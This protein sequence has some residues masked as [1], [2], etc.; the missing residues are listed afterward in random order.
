MKEDSDPCTG[1]VPLIIVEGFLSTSGS[2]AWSPLRNYV[3]GYENM[4]GDRKVMIASVGPV[5][6][7][8]DRACELYYT[9]KGG[10]VDYGAEHARQSGHKRYGRHHPTGLYPI[11]SPSNPLHF[12][13]HSIGGATIM[14]LQHLLS[15]GFFGQDT[16]PDM[17]LSVTT[18]SCPF[19]GTQIVYALGER[20]DSAPAVRS[21]SVG[22]VLA[23]AVHVLSYISPLLPKALDL[24]ADSRALSYQEC[25]F[26]SFLRHL[27][28]SD[29]AEGRD[30]TPFDVT[31][32]AADERDA[33]GEGHCNPNTYYTS[34]TAFFTN[35]VS[36]ENGKHSP[37]LTNIRIPPLYFS[38]RS[39]GSFDFESLV[40]QPSFVP[41]R[42]TPLDDFALVKP[43]V[44]RRASQVEDLSEHYWAN[45]GV[46]PVFSQ[47]HP[48]ECAETRCIHHESSP[49]S[50]P[51]PS[52]RLRRH[53]EKRLLE[54]GVWNVYTLEDTHH[55][56]ILP[57][58][59][60]SSYQQN[61]WSD[62]GDFLNNIDSQQLDV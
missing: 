62:L 5:S 4:L 60:G 10:T 43:G 13:G 52:P 11:W 16:H 54:P 9:I 26:I 6:S 7:L 45:D 40:P 58:W 42:R 14:K 31:F 18:V 21:F 53:P 24:H 61:F 38:A 44:L 1:D 2:V 46:V 3:G 8:H 32:E 55:L 35:R 15:I 17:L 28:Q 19:R 59:V 57:L 48:R 36:S 23:K 12:L 49:A 25:S 37:P 20:T 41:D 51:L 39:I 50:A 22:N 29:W 56:S 34:Y 27:W 30:A 47:W 33:N